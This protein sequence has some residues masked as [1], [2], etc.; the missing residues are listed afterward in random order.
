MSYLDDPRVYFA[1]ERTLLS[2][3]RTALSFITLGFVVER[4]AFMKNLN[5]PDQINNAHY[6]LSELIG[7]SLI[8]V[9]TFIAFVSAYQHKKFIKNLSS[10]EI[11]NGYF[12]SLGP[13]VGYTVSIGGLLML[14]WILLGFLPKLITL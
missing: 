2:W 9:G 8:L 4:Y 1:T 11:P 6:L 3:Q 12:V 10:E 5:L 13:L 7:F 14:I